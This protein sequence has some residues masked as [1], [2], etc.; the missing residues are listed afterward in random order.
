MVVVEVEAETTMMMVEGGLKVLIVQTLRN[1][2]LTSAWPTTAVQT[3]FNG[4][5]ACPAVQTVGCAACASTVSTFTTEAAFLTRQPPPPLP[6]RRPLLHPQKRN[7]AWTAFTTG[8]TVRFH[9]CSVHPLPYSH[10][11]LL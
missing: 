7:L 11:A 1:A 8:P 6:L 5:R 9:C 10:A 3:R 4:R 2:L